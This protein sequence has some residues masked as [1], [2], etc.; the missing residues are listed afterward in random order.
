M[1]IRIS[2]GTSADWLSLAAAPTFAVMAVLT[3]AF[4]SDAVDLL[5]MPDADSFP[6]AGMVP[7]YLLMGAFHLSP[8]LRLLGRRGR[9]AA[10]LRSDSRVLGA[11]EDG[12][13]AR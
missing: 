7:M 13:A 3:A 12:P 1:T 11:T 9:A 2:A 8:W 4:G 5:C 6:L 10:P